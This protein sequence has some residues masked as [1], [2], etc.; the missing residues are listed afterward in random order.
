[1]T[2]P[3][4]SALLAA[5]LALAAAAPAGAACRLALSLG[6]DVSS[7]V[8]AREYR[9]QTLGLAAALTAP[10]VVAAFLAVS[11]QPVRLHVYEWSGARQQAVR[12]DWVTIAS[13]GDLVEVAARLAG[14]VRSYAQFPTALGFAM[15]FGGRALAAGGSGCAELKLDVSGDGTNNDGLSPEM[16]RREPALAGVTV[17]G[18]VVGASVEM[19]ARYYAQY[20]IQGPGAFVERADDYVDFE[21]A[22]RRKLLRELGVFQMSEMPGGR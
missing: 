20:V 19:L 18:L 10:E 16:A 11:G 6:I 13:E 7:S 3:A 4:R 21:Q 8:D 1:M 15:L 14:Q 9:L 2:A 17:N 22:M 12:Q 5:G